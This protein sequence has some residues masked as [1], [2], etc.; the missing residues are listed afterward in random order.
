MRI[1]E[2]MDQ[3]AQ[4]VGERGG[5]QP[6]VPGFDKA[7]GNPQAFN[8]TDAAKEHEDA[9][10]ASH[11]TPATATEIPMKRFVITWGQDTPAYATSILEVAEDATIEDVIEEAKRQAD[12]TRGLVFEPSHDWDGLR[13]VQIEDQDGTPISDSIA[14]SP[15][16]EDLGVVCQSV[17][18]G[19]VNIEA[20]LHEADRQNI[21]VHPD[22][23]E[24]LRQAHAF[25][26]SR[27]KSNALAAGGAEFA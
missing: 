10:I 20:I 3:L 18:S 12:A 11:G 19:H 7:D 4:A 17:L 14:I 9:S 13:I 5:Q 21:P 24:G 25:I 6:A 8:V 15:S 26:I 1:D 27:R 16:G 22:V 2:L 23:A